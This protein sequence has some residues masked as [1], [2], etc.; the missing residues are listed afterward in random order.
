MWIH[1]GRD[2]RYCARATRVDIDDDDIMTL[3][4][5][6]H[7]GVDEG[8]IYKHQ[9]VAIDC[10][11]FSIRKARAPQEQM[12]MQVLQVSRRHISE[13]SEDFADMFRMAS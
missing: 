2:R 11:I 7:N 4:Q 3:V 8:A 1:R 9:N 12:V 6:P 13:V 10:R 5:P